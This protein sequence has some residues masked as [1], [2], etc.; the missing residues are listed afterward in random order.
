MDDCDLMMS[1]TGSSSSPVKQDQEGKEEKNPV[2]E[3]AAS[4]P[5]N[6]IKEP[7]RRSVSASY[8][9]SHGGQ[10]LVQSSSTSN[11]NNYHCNLC[12]ISVNSQSQ[13]AQV[14]PTISKYTR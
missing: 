14:R 6:V 11:N 7:R 10:A 2:K 8:S 12:Q 1:S 4:G 13:L 5:V 3:S 9:L